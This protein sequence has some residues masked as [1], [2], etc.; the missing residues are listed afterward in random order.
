MKPLLLYNYYDVID[1]VFASIIDMYY[2][3]SNY[4]DVDLKIVT[5]KPEQCIKHL[6]KN[7]SGDLVNK[8]TVDTEFEADI[9][10]CS[11]RLLYDEICKIKC[12]RLLILDSLDLSK[13]I[14]GVQP[15]IRLY[16]P[17]MS[18]EDIIFLCNPANIISGCDYA[19]QLEYYQKLSK[20]RI[21]KL[22]INYIRYL[23]DYNLEKKYFHSIF[24]YR[25]TSKYYSE[26]KRGQYF[27][28]VGRLIFEHIY[29]NNKVNYYTDGMFMQDG[30]YY[31]LK[32]FGVDAS[33]EHTPLP[34]NKEMVEKT[35]FMDKNDKILRFV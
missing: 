26:I 1:G 35:L 13:S 24:N 21:N 3:L 7:N 11:T 17:N 18:S 14:Y 34:I 20:E 25:R 19:A 4:I 27:E 31:Y 8:I 9:I 12:K 16:L 22:P 15:D 28:N 6:F 2:N 30:L 10:I 33:I 32:L 23:G 5:D 29:F